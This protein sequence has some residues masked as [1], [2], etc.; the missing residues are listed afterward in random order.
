LQHARDLMVTAACGPDSGLVDAAGEDLAAYAAQAKKF[1][2]E[3]L[4]YAMSLTAD[5]R[6]RLRDLVNSRIVVELLAV[7]LARAGDLVHLGEALAR[8]DGASSG[9]ALT[10]REGGATAPPSIPPRA[11]PAPAAPR[12]P[13]VEAM[14]ASAPAP[15]ADEAEEREASPAPMT[16]ALSVDSLRANWDRVLAAVQRR[17]TTVAGVLREGSPVR[18]DGEIVTIGFDP[19]L[20]FHREQLSDPDRRQVVEAGLQEVFGR[21]LAVEVVSQAV[22]GAAALRESPSRPKEDSRTD[23]GPA[24]AR[25]K[26]ADLAEDPRVRKLQERFGGRVLPKKEDR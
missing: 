5:A 15:A 8:L 10:A 11:A 1:T 18:V 20:G 21:A 25:R 12:S 4:L 22:T 19:E 2:V 17:R 7:K 24:L 14:T 23:H 13:R 26:G 9:P 6:R 3:S 16:G